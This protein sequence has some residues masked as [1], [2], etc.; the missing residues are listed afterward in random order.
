MAFKAQ[1][2]KV[3]FC[4]DWWPRRLTDVAWQSVVSK[5]PSSP[6]G[7]LPLSEPDHRRTW[8]ANDILTPHVL[9]FYGCNDLH[10]WMPDFFSSIL[11]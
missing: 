5:H 8:P 9:A 10:A 4:C 2:S 7:S 6:N 1:S 11:T 3:G